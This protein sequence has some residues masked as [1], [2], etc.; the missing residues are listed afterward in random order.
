M[1]R[2]VPVPAQT[3]Q[4]L[5][6][7]A[8]SSQ[9]QRANE[10]LAPP[11][12]RCV[13]AEGAAAMIG[14]HGR[15]LHELPWL[16]LDSVGQEFG[17]LPGWTM[18]EWLSMG[19]FPVGSDLR[20]RLPEWDCHLPL[21]QLYPDL[22]SAFGVPPAWPDVYGEGDLK[23]GEGLAAVQELRK[24]IRESGRMSGPFRDLIASDAAAASHAAGVG[25]GAARGSFATQHSRATVAANPTAAEISA[26]AAEAVAT[27]AAVPRIAAVRA[28]AT[29]GAA[30]GGRGLLPPPS[31]DGPQP[32]HHTIMVSQLSELSA[33]VPF[34]TNG[35]CGGGSSASSTSGVNLSNIAARPNKGRAPPELASARVSAWPLPA[36]PAKASSSQAAVTAPKG[37]SAAAVAN[38][39]LLAGYSASSGSAPPLAEDADQ[40]L[41]PPPKP[42]SV[43]ERLLHSSDQSLLLPPPPPEPSRETFLEMYPQP[44]EA[45]AAVA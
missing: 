10:Q 42:Q 28:A 1:R 41:P 4:Q 45:Q 15:K 19:R 22:S 44:G 40:P 3:Q 20:V 21:R 27:P 35:S 38:S 5:H 6:P 31:E 7:S 8:F 33:A 18:Q 34:H 37:G 30:A 9:Q 12:Y 39:A 11:T 2:Q 43:L 23:S 13:T 24:S 32:R 25:C 16:Y 36:Q 14:D 26:A 29:Q 17:P